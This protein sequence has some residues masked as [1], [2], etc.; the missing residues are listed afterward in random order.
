M[1]TGKRAGI[2]VMDQWV[3]K[4]HVSARS[5]MPKTRT[6]SIEL[7]YDDSDNAVMFYVVK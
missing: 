3:R 4:G 7:H 2:V 6:L 5:I 1:K